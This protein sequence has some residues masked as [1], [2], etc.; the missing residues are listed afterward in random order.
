VPHNCVRIRSFFGNGVVDGWLGV[1]GVV[2]L[3]VGIV[4]RADA[5]Q[6]IRE[7]TSSSDVVRLWWW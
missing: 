5:A 1:N 3:V 2:V 4:V 6:S 7:T